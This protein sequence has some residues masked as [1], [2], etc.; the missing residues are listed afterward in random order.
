MPRIQELRNVWLCRL[1]GEAVRPEFCDLTVAEG[2]IS[3]IRPAD[4]RRFLRGENP[5]CSTASAGASEERADGVV[6]AA[7][8]VA[9][10]PLVNFHDHFYSR[11]AKGLAL[12][13][14]MEDFRNILKNLWWR[15]DL[16]LDADMVEA[17]VRLGSAESL[18]CGVSYVFDHHSSPRYLRGSLAAMGGILAV[19]REV[20][21]AFADTVMS[22]YDRWGKDA[23][24]GGFFVE[25]WIAPDFSEE[26]VQVI[27]TRKKWGGRV[28]L[29]AVG[30]LTI[31]PAAHQVDL[32]TIAGGV[33]AQ[34]YGSGA[35]PAAT[36]PR[37]VSR[38]GSSTSERCRTTQLAAMGEMVTMGTPAWK[39][40]HISMAVP[41][42]AR[43]A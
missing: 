10:V 19:S 1:V 15:L 40:C 18:R 36:Q 8:R 41:M 13:G 12:P 2:K 35:P 16:A 9:T 24:A 23:G 37:N 22:T 7:G 21:A 32:R 14:S 17:C 11:L 4:Y 29:H 42:L 26:A 39:A 5:G 20:D 43:G 27:R 31:A 28:R 6:D 33:L 3:E 25:V 30:D 38:S 34:K